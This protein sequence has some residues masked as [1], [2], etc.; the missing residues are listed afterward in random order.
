MLEFAEVISEEN[1]AETILDLGVKH[2]SAFDP[3]GTVLGTIEP[4]GPTSINE[5]VIVRVST[6]HRA[7]AV[8]GRYVSIEDRLRETRFLGRVAGPFFPD[9]PDGDV[10][11]RVEIEGELAGRRTSDTRDRPAPGSIVGVLGA[12]KMG[13]MLGCSG[14][15]NLA[16]LPAGMAFPSVCRV[17]E[18]TF[19]PEMSAFLGRSAPENRIRRRC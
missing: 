2:A 1:A 16:L 19:C 13:E 3:D 17:R 18:R 15:F 4:D 10:F 9:G 6:T 8:R 12:A 14:E 11:V 5:Q 7:H